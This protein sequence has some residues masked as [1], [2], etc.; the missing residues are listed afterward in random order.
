MHYPEILT[1]TDTEVI[2]LPSGREVQIPKTS[3]LFNIWSGES[4]GDR[5]GGKPLLSFNGQPAFAELVILGTLLSAG[6][7]GV[8][9]DT[10]RHKYRTSYYPLNEIVLP[11]GPQELL[12]RIYQRASSRNGCWDV[13]CWKEETYLFAESKRH[14]RDSIRDTQRKWLEAALEDGLPITSFLIVEWSMDQIQ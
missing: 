7:Q 6:W 9:V 8:W 13:F 5:Y 1:P 11:S 10:Y 2:S 3:P 12:N 14:R 4:I